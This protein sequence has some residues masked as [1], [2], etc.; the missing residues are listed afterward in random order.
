[1][2]FWMPPHKTVNGVKS[3]PLQKCIEQVLLKNWLIVCR[4]QGVTLRWGT[5]IQFRGCQGTRVQSSWIFEG[6]PHHPLCGCCA[7]QTNFAELH[8][9]TALMS[10]AGQRFLVFYIAAAKQWL[11]WLERAT[12]KSWGGWWVGSSESRN[13]AWGWSA[14]SLN[15][16]LDAVLKNWYSV[17]PLSF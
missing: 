13:L 15:S 2:D 9:H 3:N 10:N 12:S 5:Q 7:A 1:M 4:H 14:A 11:T 8:A 16:P 17:L 6:V